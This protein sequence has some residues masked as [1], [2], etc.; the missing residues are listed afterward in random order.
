MD[1]YS[2][3][4]TLRCHFQ[5]YSFYGLLVFSFPLCLNHLRYIPGSKQIF[6]TVVF[7]RNARK[8]KIN[9]MGAFLKIDLNFNQC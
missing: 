8:N 3:A 6:M 7:S 1:K 2:K 5:Q 9:N 4:V